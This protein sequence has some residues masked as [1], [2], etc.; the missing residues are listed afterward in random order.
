MIRRG[1]GPDGEIDSRTV[2]ERQGR[3]VEIVHGRRSPPAGWPLEAL[4]YPFRRPGLATI[5]GGAAVWVLIDVATGWNLLL[6]ALLSMVAAI[7]FL[8]WQ[9]RSAARTAAGEDAPVA[10]GRA[11][12]MG[13]DD[14]VGLGR[15]LAAGGVLLAPAVIL[16]AFDRD[17]PAL[18][19]FALAL[20]WLATGALGLA[21]GRP[22]LM[23][24]WN[25][26]PWIGRHPL[27]LLAGT[28]GWWVAWLAGWAAFALR[29]EPWSTLLAASVPLRFVFLYALLV[30]AR[31]LGVVG[32]GDPEDEERPTSPA[33]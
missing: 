27:G 20:L 3:A 9:I 10:W 23:R 13:R 14:I 15:W 5:L 28:A 2:A 21:T 7:P 12:E 18:A 32:R 8:Q 29:H 33:G 31:A 26:L 24:P 16:H 17:G 19:V 25:A 1:D 30:S 22:G 6:G 4:G 11:M